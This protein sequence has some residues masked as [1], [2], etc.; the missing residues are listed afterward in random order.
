MET[1][2]L[3]SR[4]ICWAQKLSKYPFEIDYCQDK[5]KKAADAV[6]RFP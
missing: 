1:K 2:S 4:Q 6:S 3:S 5:A